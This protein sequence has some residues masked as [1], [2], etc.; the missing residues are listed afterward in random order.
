MLCYSKAP[1]DVQCI[2][3]FTYKGEAA[4]SVNKAAA[5]FRWDMHPMDKSR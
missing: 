5:G 3:Q 1:P 4:S 2:E